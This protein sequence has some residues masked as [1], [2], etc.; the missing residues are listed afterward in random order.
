MS[1]KKWNTERRN[2]RVDDIVMAADPNAVHGKW[3]IGR[4]MSVYPGSDGKIRNVK[5]KT[6]TSEYQDL[7]PKLL[8]SIQQKAMRNENSVSL[9]GGECFDI[10]TPMLLPTIYDHVICL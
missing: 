3:T 1:R 8:S 10:S 4:V 7:L 6:S 2:V 5:V 9:G